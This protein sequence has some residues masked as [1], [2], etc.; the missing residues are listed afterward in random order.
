MITSEGERTDGG[1]PATRLLLHNSCLTAAAAADALALTAFSCRRK[2]HQ[3]PCR[4]AIKHGESRR[5][6]QGASSRKTNSQVKPPVV[7]M[8][9]AATPSMPPRTMARKTHCNVQVV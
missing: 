6:P 7:S 9:T 4:R 2:R 8:M 3:W 5:T 1:Q